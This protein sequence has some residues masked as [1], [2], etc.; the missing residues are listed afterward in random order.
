VATW[1]VITIVVVVAV[2]LIAGIVIGSLLLWRRQVRRSLITLTSR[3]EAVLAAYRALETVFTSL[4]SGST[5]ELAAFAADPGSVH[6]KALEELHTR[7]VMASEELSAM[8]LPRKLWASADLI[9]TS[10]TKVASEVAKVGQASDPEA[11]LKAL[12]D[13]DVSGIRS[14]LAPMNAE[15]DRLLTEHG[16]ADPSVYGGG[17]YL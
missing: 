7:M 9:A 17:L 11:V 13:I 15:M 6:R 14:T 12:G 2:L 5:E 3:R 10:A 16:I 1:Q 4:A 8:P